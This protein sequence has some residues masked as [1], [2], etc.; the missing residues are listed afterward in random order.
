M[1]KKHV[2]TISIPFEAFGVPPGEDV[3][4]VAR[5]LSNHPMFATFQAMGAVVTIENRD[6]PEQAPPAE[7]EQE[8]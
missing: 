2:V 1:V 3:D 8:E 4:K 7:G 6:M 5:I